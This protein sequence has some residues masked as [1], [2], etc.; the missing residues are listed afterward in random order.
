MMCG[1]LPILPSFLKLLHR[2]DRRNSAY[3]G[4]LKD[5]PA[6]GSRFPGPMRCPR[7]GSAPLSEEYL[8]LEDQLLQPPAPSRDRGRGFGVHRP[9]SGGV[10][11]DGCVWRDGPGAEQGIV[12]TIQIQTRR[13]ESRDTEVGKARAKVFD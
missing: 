11:D 13:E 9:L 4:Y 12:K 10:S 1:S 5:R 7:G 6:P 8:A 3:Q 2:K